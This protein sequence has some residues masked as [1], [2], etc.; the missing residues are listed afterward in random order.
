MFKSL[1][2]KFIFLTISIVVVLSSVFSTLILFELNKMFTGYFK[3]YEKVLFSNYDIL[4]KQNVEIVDSMLSKIK[5]MEEE[6]RFTPAESSKLAADILRDIRY[7]ESGYFWADT[8]EGKNI[9]LLGK[10]SE[11]TNRIS[12]QDSKGNYL[13]KDI[14]AS[15]MKPGGGYT[16]YYFPKIGSDKSLRKRSYSLL[17]KGFNWV[18][19]TGN[20][21][22]D[23]ENILSAKK[24]DFSKGYRRTIM[25]TVVIFLLCTVF[26]VALAAIFSLRL[27][28]PLNEIVQ[29]ARKLAQGDLQISTTESYKKKSDEI[30]V[31]TNT[32]CSLAETLRHIIGKIHDMSAQI[33]SGSNEISNASEILSEGASEQAAS[34]EETTSSLEE[35]RAT[36][37]QNAANA[38]KTKVLASDTAD[39]A[40]STGDA[41][42]QTLT[43]MKN[44]AEKVS[45][46]EDIAY[47]TNLLALNAAIE[48]A[49]AGTHGKG[50]AVVAG[51]VRK[52]AEKSQNAS[53]DI[54]E[55][56]HNS[57][58]IA[59]RS[60]VQLE[61][62]I[63][64]INQTSDL[65]HEIA[66]SSEEQNTGVAQISAVMDQLNS[67][68]Q[69]TASSS[70]E[71][72][73]TAVMLRDNAEKLN[74]EVQLFKL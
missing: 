25:V 39:K 48:A 32:F 44:I 61:E 58:E 69:N 54:G 3:D 11:G 71:L 5:S 31:L 66:N 51:E 73:S 30:G 41:V 19:G 20:Y 49:R 24:E 60:G 17:T 1:K 68:T 36:V 37:E 33:A 22:D 74:K 42:K 38:N 4:V 35:I 15:G 52:L 18:V 53:K 13:I 29:N 40:H 56:A 70:E 63:E 64:M 27:T 16:D 67:T 47:Q 57:L 62:M 45:V 72:S 21:V 26:S 34:Y 65:V 12:M 9:V 14:I 55:F 10:E 2:I 28:K 50:F 59:D 43:A 46:I 23:I 7:G 8:P 6:G